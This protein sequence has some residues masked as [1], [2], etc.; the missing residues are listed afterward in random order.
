[1]SKGKPQQQKQNQK[2]HGRRSLVK[3]EL[4]K[5]RFHPYFSTKPSHSSSGLLQMPKGRPQQ[6]KQTIRDSGKRFLVKITDKRLPTALLKQLE[7]KPTKERV[8]RD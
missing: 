7:R 6:Q 3:K 1:M 4:S 8:S 5:V 2:G